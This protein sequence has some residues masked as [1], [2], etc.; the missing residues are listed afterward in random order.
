MKY[1]TLHSIRLAASLAM[2]IA[3]SLLLP[4]IASADVRIH[5]AT[6][7]NDAIASVM[8]VRDGHMLIEDSSDRSA[9]M[10]FRADSNALVVISHDN[11]SYMTVDDKAMDEMK[12]QIDAAMQ[13]MQEQLKNMPDEQRRM[14]MERMPN[15]LPQQETAKSTYSVKKSGEKDTVA[16]VSCEIMTVLK[17]GVPEG[18]GC[19]AT[20]KD[21]GISKQD[22]NTM[23]SMF[24]RLRGMAGRFGK[25][26][27]APDLSAIGG[28]PMRMT[29]TNGRQT[30]QVVR[31]ETEALDG[32]LFEVP[33]GY[34]PESMP[35]L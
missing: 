30:A 1:T 19:I 20:A 8:S 11:K 5:M 35:G 15:M 28:F 10:L 32:A 14:I 22:F 4:G 29:S 27:E 18:Q 33:A 21:M 34:S 9:S 17:D 13:Q 31:I 6:D 24:E 2:G 7:G 23:V 3:G 26:D 16:S 25:T 12:T